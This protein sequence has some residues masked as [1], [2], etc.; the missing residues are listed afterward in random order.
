MT[1]KR[2]LE[3]PPPMLTFFEEA[4]LEVL[5]DTLEAAF[6]LYLALLDRF[7]A[8]IMA[9]EYGAA[10]D[11]QDEA[12]DLA[13]RLNGGARAGHLRRERQAGPPA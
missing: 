2:A 9:G 11:A 4:R 3:A 1:R 7:H 8:A 13:V 5:P 10:Q 12:H 6:P